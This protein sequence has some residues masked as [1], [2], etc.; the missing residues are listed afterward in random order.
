MSVD[1]FFE[2]F[3]LHFF[4][5]LVPCPFLYVCLEPGGRT[6][7]VDG[8][9]TKNIC[10]TPFFFSP[11]FDVSFPL[12]GFS[13]PVR[14]R[15]FL[16]KVRYGK[17]REGVFKSN[18]TATST[19]RFALVVSFLRFFPPLLFQSERYFGCCADCYYLRLAS[20]SASSPFTTAT[21]AVVPNLTYLFFCLIRDQ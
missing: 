6:E 19:P 20:A 1:L 16:K 15:I 4:L 17:K 12:G 13:P 10:E 8:A 9:H 3:F 14:R 5:S 18:I 7:S 11:I 21:S 2:S